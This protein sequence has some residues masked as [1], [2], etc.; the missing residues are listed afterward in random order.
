MMLKR[1]TISFVASVAAMAAV[2]GCSDAT[3]TPRHGDSSS[4]TSSSGTAGEGGNGGNAAGG[5]GG[6]GTGGNTGGMGGAGGSG[7]IGGMG[8]GG[9]GGGGGA[10]GLGTLTIVDV[11]DTAC[12]QIVGTSVELYSDM[13][14]APALSRLGRVSGR[15]VASGRY[16]PGFV[17]FDLNGSGPSPAVV[18]LDPDFDITASEGNTIGL[19]A[20]DGTTVQFQRYSSND[21]P[22]G[23]PVMLGNSLGAGVDISGDAA[24]A[25]LVVWADA[26]NM[27][28]RSVDASG[29]AGAAFTFA[30]GM[31]T[32]SI[33]VSLARGAQEFALAW[34]ADDSGKTHTRFVRITT[35]GIAGS[36]VDLTG[37]SSA[38]YVVKLVAVP[39]GYALLVHL[40]TLSKEVVVV[41]LDSAGKVTGPAHRFLGTKFA[42]DLGANGTNLGLVAKRAD[43]SAEFRLLDAKGDASG[44]WKCLDAPSDDTYDQA[45]IDADGTGWAIVYRTPGGGEKF[46]RT[47]LTGTAP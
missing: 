44:N 38:A 26:M 35:T 29:S 23:S 25:S 12:D 5:M 1:Q 6:G 7:G 17:T 21:G 30:D 3:S 27:N 15:R 11:P 36:V 16:V 46:V 18:G 14:G 31:P 10:G 13:S 47:N 28:G 41:L 43:G 32:K 42:W 19:V 45:G 24:G 22:M 39:S 40:G 2:V 37:A 33:A 34:S 8:S 20:A 4:A 9:A